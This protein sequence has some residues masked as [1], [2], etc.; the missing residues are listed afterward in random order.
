MIRPRPARWFEILAARDDA[1]LVL[2]ALGS[3]GA[4]ELE[5]RAAAHLPGEFAELEPLVAQFIELASRYGA[6]WPRSRER[7]SP[8]P[9]R[10]AV[11]L[12][13]C[14]AAIR[15]WGEAA[16]PVIARLQRLDTE[17][18]EL[19]LWSGVLQAIDDPSIDFG[20]LRSNGPV[21]H[22][23]LFAFPA[24]A[25]VELP[26]DALAR[27]VD[28]GSVRCVLAVGA[29]PHIAA[30]AQQ[31]AALKG[32]AHGVPPW[33][34][35]SASEVLAA[36]ADRRQANES[37]SAI[38]AAELEA[39]HARHDLLTALGD[40]HRL[41]W[42]TRHVRALESDELFCWIT[43]WTSD[44]RDASLS[45]AVA[46]SGARA[47]VHFPE[48]PGDMRPP[49]LL[50]NPWWARPFEIFSRAI[51]MPSRNEADPSALLA[52][53]VPLMFGY[54]FGDVG[55]GAVLAIG[56]ALLA[57]RYPIARLFVAGGLSAIA[58]G[59]LFGSVF[60]MHGV[61]APRWIDPLEDPLA[62]LVVPLYGGA[63]LMTLGL[64][65]S[66]FEYRWRGEFG[67]WLLTDAGL[68]L[69]YAGLM[70]SFLRSE[71]LLAAAAGALWFCCGHGI[72]ARSFGAGLASAGELVE[73]LLQ[74]GINTLSFSR[75]GA[76]AL[77]HAG[78]SAAI[79]ALVHAAGHPAV[80]VLVLVAGN[81]VVIV[82]ET[83]VVSIQTTRLVLFEFFTRFLAGEGR[84]FHPLP[85]PSALAQ[86]VA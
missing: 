74:I 41:Q 13:R 14:L 11:T 22:K 18:A 47:L 29:Q 44:F 68:V 30:I 70:A 3:T 7:F 58:F 2:G 81:V 1:T 83:L 5:A 10:P 40:A 66:A 62:I 86:E 60:S 75:V 32:S 52:L 33:F 39:I 71:A 16:E 6:Y 25:N 35:G 69:A 84:A 72:A 43:G 56:G 28:A 45:A 34:A 82:L 61:I 76:F 31:C 49:L 48:P 20:E 54:M 21:L 64:A 23:G 78:L 12:A 26:R 85:T 53:A 67:R 50:F 8:F 9:E 77:A 4:V 51:G 59:I 37:E 17:R 19:G 73:R 27:C 24:G 46:A 15:A 57:R 38:A 79:V 80:A 36:I 63:A 42:V 65:L 55:Q